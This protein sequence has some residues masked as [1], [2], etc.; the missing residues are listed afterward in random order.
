ML[1]YRLAE[2]PHRLGQCH[3]QAVL[4]P[5]RF[6]LLHGVCCEHAD[7]ICCPLISIEGQLLISTPALALE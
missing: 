4:K 1:S 2:P 3:I 5:W 6:R 7:V